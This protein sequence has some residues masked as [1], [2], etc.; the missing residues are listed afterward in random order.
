VLLLHGEDAERELVA[1]LLREGGWTVSE[2]AD[3]PRAGA[4]DLALVERRLA[5]A[6]P[7]LTERLRTRFALPRV[8]LLEPRMRPG[9]VLALL[10]E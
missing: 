1:A 2:S 5:L 9:A 6:D 4:F 10:E 7:A 8:G 3:E